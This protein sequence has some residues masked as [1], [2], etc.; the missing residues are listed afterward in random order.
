M[1]ATPRSLGHWKVLLI[2]PDQEMGATL[3]GLLDR[4]LP[5]SQVNE[6]NSYP[7]RA[8]LEEALLEYG[9][10][11]CFVDSTSNQEWAQALLSDL[12]ML[13]SKLPVVAVH[14]QSNPDFI[15]RTL[16]AGA[17][18]VLIHPLGED[19]FVSVLERLHAVHGANHH[20]GKLIAM[21]PAKGAC[22]ASTLSCNLA[23]YAS[24]AGLSRILLADLDPLTGTIPFL[25]KLKSLY[26]FVDALTRSTSLDED[27]WRGLVANW[28]GI[29]VL[30]SPDKPVHGIDEQSDASAMLQFA[31]MTYDLVV[32]DTNVPYGPWALSIARNCD[33]LLLVTTNELASLQA[34]QKALAYFD[35]NRIERSK[36]RV[37]VNRFS[38]D[39]G[40]SQE[41]IEAALHTEVYHLIPSDYETINR[42]L[43]EGRAVPRTTAIGRSIATLV[44]KLTGK[45]VLQPKPKSSSLTNLFGLLRR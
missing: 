9:T 3:H 38:K 41:V 1:A 8:V 35:R 4:L 44:E 5:F 28:G 26:S 15:L 14:G 34:A 7:T 19:Q 27:I 42:S 17:T 32:T 25:L 18:E 11:L 31:G 30:L 21:I 23:H 36:V 40:L 2:V 45:V 6:L 39:F 13:N 22:G 29:D 20:T 43:V 33:E 12:A 16:R 10:T 37:V 24:R